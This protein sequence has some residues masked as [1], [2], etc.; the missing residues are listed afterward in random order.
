VKES[1]PDCW[2]FWLHASSPERLDAGIRE[3]ANVLQLPGRYDTDNVLRLVEM[4]LRG[5]GKKWLL[6]LDNADLEDVLFKP[7]ERT[8]RKRTI[9]FL[10]IPSCGQTLLTTRHTNVASQFVDDC[11]IIIVGPMTKSDASNLFRK[12]AGENHDATDVGDL[13][14]ALGY[15]PLAIAHAAA[16]IVRKVPLCT[17]QT[18][19]GYLEELR[20]AAK[21]D[22]NFLTAS[23]NELRRDYEANNSV[24]ITWQV[25]F[26]HIRHIRPS[27]ADR[28]S[29]MS[30]YDHRS[31]PR[32]LLNTQQTDVDPTG[33]Q[34]SA[35][36]HLDEDILILYE[37]HL[38]GI[39]LGNETLNFHPLVQLA[40]RKWLK[41]QDQE[42]RWLRE[43]LLN[44][45]NA[46]P[47][48][49]Y[50]FSPQWRILLPHFE[51]A[52]THELQVRESAL[53]LAGICY[54][55]SH[56]I[57]ITSGCSVSQKWARRCLAEL[58]HHLGESHIWTLHAELQLAEVLST[59]GK[60]EEAQ[61]MLRHC[62]SLAEKHF[63][64][65]HEW[66]R[67]YAMCL[68]KEGHVKVS[69]GQLIDAKTLFRRALD[70]CDK[71]PVIGYILECVK[72][73]KDVLLRQEKKPEAET[74]CRQALEACKSHYESEA[75][76]TLEV[77]EILADV[78][79]ETGDL[80][81][82]LGLYND[83]SAWYEY[84]HGVG[85]STL[86]AM[87]KIART[88]NAQNKNQEAVNWWLRVHQLTSDRYGKDNSTTLFSA[89]GYARAL[90]DI[91]KANQALDVMKA[92]ATNSQR[93]LG[94]DHEL[95]ISMTQT[96][97][98]LE[99]GREVEEKLRVCEGTRR[100]LGETK[101]VLEEQ[102][103]KFEEI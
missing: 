76:C 36:A 55:T 64:S 25:S 37:F 41:W 50:I 51:L 84:I 85:H 68:L 15:I 47:D 28:L 93:T 80:E 98:M 23:Y 100:V 38:I 102:L 1:S 81:G 5:S 88:L 16:F 22:A 56:H 29:L 30:F 94:P 77:T 101:R 62:S 20:K 95:S 43:S 2:V 53:I 46:L 72:S 12:T 97:A 71:H 33:Q 59:C 89:Q 35:S 21:P 54:A 86:R 44:L 32:T 66:G 73:L 39:G 87:N 83:V 79:Y 6:I 8:T 18:Y 92:C 40:A 65:S 60:E 61:L 10:A 75:Q 19:L 63:P 58:T 7:V 57:R 70:V 103:R 45:R 67:L 49:E 96:V 14:D 99:L 91:G 13:V 3:L 74:I 27:A 78:L 42:D 17:I 52:L 82:A 4:W 26:E 90:K 69:Q 11:D 9:D 48:A 31:I 34:M 24:I